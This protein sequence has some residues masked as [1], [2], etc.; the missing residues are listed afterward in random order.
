MKQ[1]NVIAKLLLVLVLLAGGA[2]VA[3]RGFREPVIVAKVRRA[4][5]VDA[6]P[7]SVV[8]HA[9][10]DLQELTIE[11]SGRVVECARLEPGKSFHKG[12]ILLR[13]DTSELERAMA[14]KK[15]QFASSRALAKIVDNRDLEKQLAER[16]LENARKLFALDGGAAEDVN[17]AQRALD[18]VRREIE[19]AEF[20]ARKDAKDH[21][22]ANATF[23]LQLKKM[24][25]V[26]P[27]DGMVVGTPVNVGTLVSSG[28]VVGTFYSNDRVVVAKISEEDIAKV[29][30]GDLARVQ[31][32]TFPGE[33][34]DARVIKRLP[35]ADAETRRYDV[36]LEVKADLM[37]LLPNSTGEVTITVGTH[38]NVPLIPRRALFTGNNGP[39]VSVVKGGRVERRTVEVG[40][41]ALDVAEVTKGLDPGEEVIVDPNPDQFGDGQHVRVT[42]SP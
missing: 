26:A 14:E 41:R 16:A 38:D 25:V 37:R 2:Y 23:E 20:T 10:K 24:T 33:D 19:V 36:Y 9:D 13:L 31:L 39:M 30:D 6:V 7:G 35:F 8:V 11:G 22:E 42:A 28:Q 34:F 21:E 17:R 27:A 3:L 1:G 5:A 15:R 29:K 18:T 4:T 12:E 32:L 40:Y